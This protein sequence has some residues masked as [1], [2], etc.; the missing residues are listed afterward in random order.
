MNIDI[1]ID[2]HTLAVEVIDT[3]TAANLRDKLAFCNKHG[4]DF[5]VRDACIILLDYMG[6]PHGM[7]SESK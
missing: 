2:H 3:I 1:E 4:V 7:F 6:E 5:L